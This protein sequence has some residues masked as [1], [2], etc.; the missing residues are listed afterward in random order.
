MQESL[1]GRGSQSH[2]AHPSV[3]KKNNVSTHCIPW[4]V[5]VQK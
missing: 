4:G 1:R 3:S 5:S 2:L